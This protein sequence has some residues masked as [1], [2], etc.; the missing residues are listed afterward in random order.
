[1]TNHKDADFTVAAEGPPATPEPTSRL[2][3]TLC[4]GGTCPTVYSTDRD[5]VLVQGS[6]VTG[7]AVPDGELLVEI[8]RE[9]LIEAARRVQEQD[10]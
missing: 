6:A 3:I 5:T 9:L 1:M 7:I 4:G 8:P 2:V 10:S